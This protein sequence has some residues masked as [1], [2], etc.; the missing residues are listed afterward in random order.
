MSEK[1]YVCIDLKSFYASV[2]CAARGL[3]PLDTNLVVAD[4]TRTE[5]TICLAVTPSLKA[6]GISGRARLFEVVERVGR[7]N[8]ERR[9]RAPKR[10]FSGE[11]HFGSELERD[12]T[13]KIDYIVAPPRMAL[14]MQVSAQIYD[15]YLRY[16]APED[17]HVYSVD[18][19]FIDVTHYLRTYRATPREIAMKLIR[20]VLKETGITA[21]V[22]IGTN[23][24]LAKI[25]MDIDAKHMQPD[26]NGVRISELDEMSYRRRL[27]SHTPITDFWRIGRGI[28]GRLEKY[29]I[30]TMGDIALV[31]EAGES[32]YLNED[33]LYKL[34]G[35]NAEL[36]IDH[37][38]GFEP[39]T[40]QDIKAYRPRAHSLSCGQVLSEPYEFDKA[41]LIIRE[42]ADNLSMD[43]FSKGL[44]TDQIVLDVCYDIENLTDT[45]RAR[46]YKGA[47]H[48]DHYGRKAPA[49]SHGSL[50]LEK[51][52]SS[53]ERITEAAVR[54][55]DRIADPSLLVRRMYICANR[56]MPEA[57]LDKGPVYEQLDLFTDPEE[58]KRE[59]LRG[60]RARERERSRQEAVLSIRERFGKNALLKGMNFEEGATAMERNAQIGGHR[61]GDGSES[62]ALQPVKKNG[63]SGTTSVSDPAKE[64]GM[65]SQNGYESIIGLPHHV[66]ESRPHMSN[67][68]R[69]AQ[70]APFAALTGFDGMVEETA[71]RVEARP[72]L[73]DNEKR[74]IDLRLRELYARVGERPEA[75]FTVFVPDGRKQ[76]GALVT[77][78]G[79]VL[80]IN[81]QTRTLLFDDGTGLMLDDIV[82]ADA[83]ERRP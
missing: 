53:T 33:F 28:A 15:I 13:L 49:S 2:E 23:L 41:R 77:L 19:V 5:K 58:L 68:D 83:E 29:G 46:R 37:A 64:G 78:S 65:K 66:S 59:F 42:M 21:T 8:A 72:L 22:G 69:A 45:E 38:W 14:Y 25:A 36:I 20:D 79:R 24:Y 74:V 18:E 30:R 16:I 40:M 32:G 82:S 4:L 50:N 47:V 44:V 75:S 61:A 10:E 57:A 55:F 62:S 52:T 26:E 80:A 51:P 27:W 11:S 71:R 67:Y 54:L 35:I 48:T 60:E 7:L 43:V 81:T 76:G 39:C 6:M 31:S 1:S 34:F 3:D 17:I 73:D 70:F 9:L 56:V 12:K 63:P